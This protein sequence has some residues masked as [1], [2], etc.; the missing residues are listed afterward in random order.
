VA[1]TAT[2]AT[3]V[4][5]HQTS[6]MPPLAVIAIIAA[7]GIAVCAVWLIWRRLQHRQEV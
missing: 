4:A 3:G 5:A 7:I 2:V 6:G 1:G